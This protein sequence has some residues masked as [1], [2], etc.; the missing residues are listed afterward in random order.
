MKIAAALP[1]EVDRNGLGLHDG[2][3]AASPEGEFLIVAR[4]S[5]TELRTKLPSGH[6]EPILAFDYVELI[7]DGDHAAA[8]R[9]MMQAKR[10]ERMGPPLPFDEEEEAMRGAMP[11]GTSVT[12]RRG[13]VDPE[14]ADP[15]DPTRNIGRGD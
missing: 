11:E 7:D 3:I 1:K 5:V 9:R 15:D 8:A 2:K 13:T 12:I 14:A 6:V 4:M 10:D